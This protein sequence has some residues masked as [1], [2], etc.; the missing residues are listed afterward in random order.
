MD[1]KEE[2]QVGCQTDQFIDREMDGQTEYKPRKTG[3][4]RQ[5]QIYDLDVG[6]LIYSR[7]Q[8]IYHTL[9]ADILS[10]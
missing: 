4:D 8:S 6:F 2:A 10:V 9:L 1:R 5:T 7:V 3:I